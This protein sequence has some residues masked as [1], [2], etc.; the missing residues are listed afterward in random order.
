[1]QLNDA[2]ARCVGQDLIQRAVC[3]QRA[4]LQ[5]C[6]GYWGQV[7]QCPGGRAALQTN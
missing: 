3:E 5:H 1:M 4:R 2:L 6:E 7:P